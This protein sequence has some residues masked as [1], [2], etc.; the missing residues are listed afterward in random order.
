MKDNGNFRTYA[1]IRSN[2]QGVF[3]LGKNCWKLVFGLAMLSSGTAFT[4]F[5]YMYIDN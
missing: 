4:T 5:L 2:L 3:I 1:D